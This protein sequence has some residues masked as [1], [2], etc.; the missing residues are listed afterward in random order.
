VKNEVWEERI[1]QTLA[2]DMNKTSTRQLKYK[3][4]QNTPNLRI[5]QDK[6]WVK[7]DLFMTID[8]KKAKMDVI[9]E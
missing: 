5:K 4:I 7:F 9:I 1:P 8:T 3:T 2:E 6:S